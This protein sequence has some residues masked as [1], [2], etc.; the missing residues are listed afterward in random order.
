M[1]KVKKALIIIAIYAALGFLLMLFIIHYYED[2]GKKEAIEKQEKVTAT[3]TSLDP[4]ILEG[5][6]DTV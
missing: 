6:Y 3:V 5:L 4:H 1:D 2:L